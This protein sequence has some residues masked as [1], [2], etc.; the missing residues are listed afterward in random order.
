M[1]GGS[2][3]NEQSVRIELQT[4][5]FAGIWGHHMAQA[6]LLE[7]G[8]VEE[9]I[10]AA[11]AVG[12]DRLQ[13]MSTGHVSPD[14]FTHGS[15]AQRASWFRRGLESGRPPELRRPSAT[16]LPPAAAARSLL[17]RPP[18]AVQSDSLK[19]GS[20]IACDAGFVS[21]GDDVRPGQSPSDQLGPTVRLLVVRDGR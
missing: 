3:S 21:C 13:R 18:N 6:G 5:C 16:R 20:G 12:D 1:R 15:S 19:P 2:S 8:D 4:D 7:A 9:G 14:A 17:R 11:A 10:G